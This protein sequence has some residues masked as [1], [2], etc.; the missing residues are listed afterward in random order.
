[1]KAQR[2]LVTSITGLALVSCIP[3][4]TRGIQGVDVSHHQGP[5]DWDVLSGH[6]VRFAYI[7][8]TEGTDWNDPAYRSHAEA[9]RSRGLLVGAYHYFSF[10]SDPERQAMHFLAS[11]DLR[12]GDMLPAVDIENQGNCLRDPD[13]ETLRA[14]LRIFIS[15][16]ARS[17]GREPMLYM[18]AWFH[19]RYFGSH[20]L[21]APLWIRAP[22]WRPSEGSPWAIWQYATTRIPG[23]DGAV[24]LNVLRGG[25]STLAELRYDP[26]HRYIAPAQ[27]QSGSTAAIGA[28]AP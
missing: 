23:A 13:P 27:G 25:E 12:P 10:C 3:P 22:Y 15:V 24:D 19:W 20:P 26:A 4:G 18:T 14:N 7:K 9:A 16:V 5:M 21:T 6:G 28:S 11:L 17:T 8:A 2:I 1:M